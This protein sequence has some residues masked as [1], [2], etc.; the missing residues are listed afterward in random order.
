MLNRVTIM[1]RLTKDPELRRTNTGKPVVSFSVAVDRTFGEGTD[2]FD[3]VAWS[4][5]GEFVDSY[6]TKGKMIAVDGRLQTRTW[7]KDGRKCKAVEIIVEQAHFCGSKSDDNS[8]PAR[9]VDVAPA[10]PVDVEFTEEI[11][12]DGHLPF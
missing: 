10:R 2:F 1:G 11:E 12:D 4:K 6:F 8:A 3:C 7:E 5:T 9:P